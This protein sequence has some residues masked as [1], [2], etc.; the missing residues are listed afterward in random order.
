M[1]KTR[2]HCMTGPELVPSA[3]WRRKLCWLHTTRIF[4]SELPSAVGTSHAGEAGKNPSLAF[5]LLGE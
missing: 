3:Y 1:K 2:L 5:K 4:T